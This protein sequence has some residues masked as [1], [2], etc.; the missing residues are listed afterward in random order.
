MTSPVPSSLS[1]NGI[2]LVVVSYH[3]PDALDQL[4][5]SAEEQATDIVVVNVEGDPAIRET[6]LSRGARLINLPDNPG[7]A[8]A[9][10]AAVRTVS[11]PLVA[12]AN[13]DLVLSRDCMSILVEQICGG[14]DVAVPRLCRPDTRTEPSI[15][16]L[17]SPATLALEWAL[18]PDRP[19]GILLRRGIQAWL[20]IQ[21]WRR[22]E[23]PEAI[24]AAEAALVVTRTEL[25]RQHLLPECYFM[26]WEEQEWFHQLRGDGRTV[27]YV[28]SAVAVHAGW[29][30]LRADKA[31]LLAR[32]AVRCLARTSGSWA[33]TLGWPTCVAW[34]LRLW[35]TDCL[36]AILAPS[37]AAR[38]RALT[39]SAGLVAAL[40]A[41]R[42]IPRPSRPSHQAVGG[43]ATTAQS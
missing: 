23:G 10:N 11:T 6:A 20:P 12:F 37:S 38:Q 28:P 26:Y 5:A 27:V 7:Y 36:R 15:A 9:V 39:R 40:A 21:K 33:A 19:P 25:L 17:L 41:W 34:W 35:L 30:A 8:A 13:D 16:A 3:R 32:N 31:R 43:V 1:R 18:L 4:I 42:E 29:D 14:A 22:P 24:D 2:T